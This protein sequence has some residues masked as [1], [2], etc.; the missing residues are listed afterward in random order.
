MDYRQHIIFFGILIFSSSLWGQTLSKP[1]C[2][3]EAY[4]FSDSTLIELFHENDE[5]TIVLEIGQ[6]N[7][8]FF[9]EY[10]EPFYVH[11]TKTVSCKVTHPDYNDSKLAVIKVYKNSES[12]I[13]LTGK[14]IDANL[15]DGKKGNSE[16]T[17]SDWSYINNEEV[18]FRVICTDRNLEEI[19]LLSYVSTS[20]KILPPRKVVLH[21]HLK[22]GKTV[23][24]RTANTVGSFKNTEQNWSHVVRL[25]GKP[26]LRK[27]LRKTE[28][29]TLTAYAQK[30]K[31]IPQTMVFDEI[32]AR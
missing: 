26:K 27:I 11:Q 21:A 22:N 20:Q 13:L 2:K 10:T 16:L 17:D 8:T 28:F 30:K 7:N 15:L 1:T 19:E 23:H 6:G 25:S 14:D 12:S 5:G 29:F 24:V 18:E 32:L 31:D 3:V 9:R 4:F